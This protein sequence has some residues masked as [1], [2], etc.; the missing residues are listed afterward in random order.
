QFF[1]KDFRPLTLIFGLAVPYLAVAPA[2]FA[3]GYD[4]VALVLQNIATGGLLVLGGV[5]YLRRWR[6]APLSIGGLSALY[7][8]A[9][10][11]FLLCAG[12]IVATAQWSIGYPPDNWAEKLNTIVAVLAL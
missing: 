5:E 2:L 8:V 10:T 4:G 6:E 11:S 1:N 9:G 12:V 7:F 3:Y